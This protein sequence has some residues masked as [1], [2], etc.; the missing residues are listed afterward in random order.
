[1]SFMEQRHAT[2]TT[3][4]TNDDDDDDGKNGISAVIR[5]ATIAAAQQHNEIT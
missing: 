1:M 2:M 5:I 4:T 3:T